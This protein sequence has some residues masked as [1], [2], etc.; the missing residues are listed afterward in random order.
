MRRAAFLTLSD[1]TGF[2][3]DDD[4]AHEPMRRRGWRVDTVPWDAQ[5]IDWHRYDIVVIRSTWDYQHRA[6]A[7]LE[8]LD[9][10]EGAG[11]RLEN[12][13]DIVRW[14]MR[15][16]YLRDLAAHG[17]ATLP[18][19]WREGLASGELL[20]MF[21]AVQSE[22]VIIKPIMGG[23]AQGAYRLD[24]ARARALAAEIE[25]YYATKPLMMQPFEPAVVSEGEYSL[26]YF[27]GAYSHCVLKVP[28]AGDFRVQEEHGGNILAVNA[29]PALREAGSAAMAA[30]P[31]TLLYARADFVRH[32][33]GTFRV[34]E[35]ELVE[36][37]L[38]LRMD[39][40]APDR[41]AEAIIA[42]AAAPPGGAH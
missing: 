13:L 6:A 37:A 7:F 32:Q 1:P 42:R 22:E 16:T 15:K 33:D 25:P 24:R 18:T 12:S 8:T 26:F 14:N 10:I 35:L 9:A 5:G 31:E 4:L 30:I 20:P 39:P 3:I 36:P 19:V 2:V 29:E 28:K 21:D 40:D 27:N 11:T 34:M 38:Y 23:N 41:F 17:V